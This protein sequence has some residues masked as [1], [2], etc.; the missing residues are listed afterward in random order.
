MCTSCII[1]VSLLD[2]PA[3]VPI[4]CL[5]VKGPNDYSYG[6]ALAYLTHIDSELEAANTGAQ[7]FMESNGVDMEELAYLLATTIPNCIS[8][9]FNPRGSKNSIEASIK[10]L[11]QAIDAATV[12]ERP[13]ESQEAWLAQRPPARRLATSNARKAHGGKAVAPSL[14]QQGPATIPSAV[15]ELPASFLSRAE[16]VASLKDE[17]LGGEK[18]RVLA[19]GMGGAGK[20]TLACALVRE[21]EVLAQFDR[22]VWVSI[23]QVGNCFYQFCL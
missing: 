11:I 8:V 12:H 13:A 6:D 15:P 4:V 17:V 3:G 5:N 14:Q 19:Y 7:A 18:E 20:T 9:D 16:N 21:K 23:G 2:D 10:D 22:L 1:S